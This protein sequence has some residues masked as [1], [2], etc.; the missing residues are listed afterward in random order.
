MKYQ[1]GHE[2]ISGNTSRECFAAIRR[3]WWHKPTTAEMYE[4]ASK[5]MGYVVATPRQYLDAML[6]LGELKKISPGGTDKKGAN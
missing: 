4:T 2:V 5:L 3:A 1:M 6:K